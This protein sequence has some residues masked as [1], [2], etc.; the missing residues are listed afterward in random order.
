[1]MFSISWFPNSC[2]NTFN[3]LA[4]TISQIQEENQ[5]TL[6]KPNQPTKKPTN[7]TVWRWE[8]LH[9]PSTF[10]TFTLRIHTGFLYT[11]TYTHPRILKRILPSHITVFLSVY[12][13]TG[14]VWRREKYY[15][16]ATM[17]YIMPF[18]SLILEWIFIL[19]PI[20]RPKHSKVG[21]H[22]S[23]ENAE[24]IQP[25]HVYKIYNL[26]LTSVSQVKMF[27]VL[28]YHR[29]TFKLRKT[30]LENFCHR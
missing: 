7:S 10:I 20:N 25:L 27:L 1:M 9:C 28:C 30:E 4:S 29:H 24:I 26:L 6:I 14:E 3:P 5:K 16:T 15:D 8:F 17:T 2:Q 22:S 12:E 21:K 18:N 11:E 23:E 13:S 19:W